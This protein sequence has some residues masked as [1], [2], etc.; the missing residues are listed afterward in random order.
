MYFFMLSFRCVK[1]SKH[2]ERPK[3]SYPAPG[4][5]WIAPERDDRVCCCVLAALPFSNPPN[6]LAHDERKNPRAKKS[7]RHHQNRRAYRRSTL[8][9]GEDE[10]P[11]PV[12]CH[13]VQCDLSRSEDVQV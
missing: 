2:S 1:C 10:E 3:L 5:A 4:D 13:R 12:R 7:P 9:P 11:N 8:S 6:Q